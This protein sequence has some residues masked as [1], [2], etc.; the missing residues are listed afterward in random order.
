MLRRSGS[1]QE[2]LA[3]PCEA[4]GLRPQL[5]FL[6]QTP[7]WAPLSA[8][9]AH[10]RQWLTRMQARPSFLATTWEKVAAQAAAARAAAA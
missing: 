1:R 10:L 7:E 2:D 8:P 3:K 4:V 6:A 5:D 9:H